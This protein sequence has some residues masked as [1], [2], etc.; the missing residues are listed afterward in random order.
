[1]RRPQTEDNAYF[2]RDPG[3]I[4]EIEESCGNVDTSVASGKVM[5]GDKGGLEFQGRRTLALGDPMSRARQ[6]WLH[7]RI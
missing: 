4:K 1:M 6:E 5:E 3:T 7:V 2:I